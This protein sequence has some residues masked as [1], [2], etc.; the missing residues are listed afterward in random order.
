MSVISRDGATY[1]ILTNPASAHRSQLWLRSRV[2]LL[3]SFSGE[4]LSTLPGSTLDADTVVRLC[5]VFKECGVRD[6]KLTGGDPALWP[7]LVDCV[8]RLKNQVGVPRLEVICVIR[9]LGFLCGI[10]GC[11]PGSSQF[12]LGYAKAGIAPAHHRHR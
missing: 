5:A 2:L 6:F 8:R 12:E 4:G 10:A 7:P 1:G 3:P 11:R 9:A